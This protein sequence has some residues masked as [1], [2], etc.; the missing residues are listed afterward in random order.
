MMWEDFSESLEALRRKGRF[1]QLR[2][3]HSD[4]VYLTDSQGRRTVNFG[5]NDYLGLA[6]WLAEQQKRRLNVC[7][8]CFLD[9]F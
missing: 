6:G 4:G 9:F 8:N 7:S 3:M 5:S 1:R 2:P